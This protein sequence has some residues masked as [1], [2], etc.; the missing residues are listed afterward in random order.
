ML[1]IPLSLHL[2]VTHDL[3]FEL[4]LQLKQLNLLLVL[5]DLVLQVADLV[6]LGRVAQHCRSHRKVL[7]DVAYVTHCQV[8]R[9]VLHFV[10]ETLYFSDVFLLLMGKFLHI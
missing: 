1:K 2:L 4:K 3:V 6:V 10:L 7:V 9:Q 8:S 5:L